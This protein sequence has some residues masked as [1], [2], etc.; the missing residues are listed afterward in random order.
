M[1]PS[2]IKLKVLLV[3]SV[4][5]VL[6]ETVDFLNNITSFLGSIN[7]DITVT[8]FL[9]EIVPLTYENRNKFEKTEAT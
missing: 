4:L 9:F 1:L 5:S 6:Q 3:T 8:V 2:F 7:V